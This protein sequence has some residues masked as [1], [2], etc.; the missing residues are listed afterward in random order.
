M[1]SDKLVYDLIGFSCLSVYSIAMFYIDSVRQDYMDHYNGNEPKVTLP[2]VCF[3]VHALL[4][5]FVQIGQMSY[6][7]GLQQLPSR[8]CLL[9]ASVVLTLI[10]LYLLLTIYLQT[11]I[12]QLL[13]WL[14][15]L[16]YVKITVTMVKYIPQV[17]LNYSRKSTIGWSI[18][19]CTLDLIGSSMS[20]LQL[21][22]DCY[23][24][25][26]WSGLVGDI[27]KFLLGLL[28][29]GFDLIFMTQHYFLYSD[30]ER[31]RGEYGTLKDEEDGGK[32]EGEGWWS[33]RGGGGGGGEL[34]LDEEEDR[35]RDEEEK[36]GRDKGPSSLSN[37]RPPSSPSS[38]TR[39]VAFTV[40]QRVMY[41]TAMG[42]DTSVHYSEI[43]AIHRDAV[44]GVPYYTIRYHLQTVDGRHS[45]RERQTDESRLRHCSEGDLETAATPS[46][47]QDISPVR[48]YALHETSEYDTT[49]SPVYETSEAMWD[50]QV[51]GV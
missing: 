40:G 16:S 21:F 22:L 32:R 17:L 23:D 8:P 7:N 28:S 26:D 34:L 35:T 2:D 49:T 14:N 30:H 50:S 44:D 9:S 39:P 3:A 4:F 33:R 27:V 51:T 13:Y 24:T 6:F 42:P 18:T 48:S 46:K 37:Y 1:V 25:S 29:L 38:K 47:E 19:A 12:F 36:Q 31:G 11:S 43:V 15:F 10:I 41:T 5:T 20:M 45:V